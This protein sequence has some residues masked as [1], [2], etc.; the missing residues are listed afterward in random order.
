MNVLQKNGGLSRDQ[1]AQKL[2]SFKANKTYVFQSV[3]NSVT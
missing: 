3:D 2:L 1:I